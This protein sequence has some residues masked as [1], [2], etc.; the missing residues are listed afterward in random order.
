MPILHPL[1]HVPVYEIVLLIL[2]F[3]VSSVKPHFQKSRGRLAADWASAP[4]LRLRATP[5]E[6][7]AFGA[8]E[9]FKSE[10]S[11]SE[12]Y[13]QSGPNRE[14]SVRDTAAIAI[15]GAVSVDKCSIARTAAGRPQP[16]TAIAIV[17]FISTPRVTICR[18]PTLPRTIR[19]EIPVY[20]GDTEKK[21]LISGILTR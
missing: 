1:P 12:I 13:P 19:T 5:A 11:R 7:C 6:I 18:S 16:P 17:S 4:H 8:V 21:H 15:D 14:I 10:D 9:D 20:F 3:N 2:F